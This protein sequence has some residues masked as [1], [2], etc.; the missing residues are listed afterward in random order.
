M[1]LEAT[2]GTVLQIVAE[3]PDATSAVSTLAELV[4]SGFGET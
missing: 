2:Q 1:L 4:E 3:G